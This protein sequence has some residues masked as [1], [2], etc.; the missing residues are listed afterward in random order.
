MWIELFRPHQF[1][2]RYREYGLIFPNFR[3]QSTVTEETVPHNICGVCFKPYNAPRILPCLH[4]LCQQFLH[5]E[6]EKS[7]SQQ[8]FKCPTCERS[9]GIPVGGASVLPHNLHLGFQVQ[10]A[11]YMSK[12]VSNSEVCC[13]ECIDGHN[14]PAVVFCCTCRQFLCKLCHD[15]HRSSRKLSKHDTVGLDHEGAKHVQTTMKPREY[16]CSQPKHEDN[17]LNFYCVSCNMLVCRDC[18]RVAHKD[19]GVSELSTVAEALQDD[20]RGTLQ[21]VQDTLAGAIDANEKTMKQVETSK[22]EAELAIKQAFEQLHAKLE[23]RKKSLLSELETIA[24]THT[25]S[26]IFQR[27][28]LEKIQHDISHYPEV[29]SHILQTHTDHEVV[30]MGELIVSELKATLRKVQNVSSS[31]SQYD[32]IYAHLQIDSLLQEVSRLGYVYDQ[33]P[34]P[35][36]SIITFPSVSRINTK[37][38]MKLDTRMLNGERCPHGG[39]QVEAEMRSNAQNGAVVYGEVEDHRDGTYTIALTPQ[40]AGP[41]QLVITMDG[42]HV[43]NSPHDLDVRPKYSNLTLCNVITHRKSFCISL[44]D[45][46]DIYVV[47]LRRH[48]I[49]VYDQTGQLKNTI[50]SYGSGDGQFRGPSGICIKGDVLYVADCK[51]HRVQKLTSG[52]EFLHHFGQKAGSGQG[53][54]K[55]P[56]AVIVDSNNRLIVAD[57]NNHRIQIFNEDGGWLLTIDGNSSGNPFLR[58]PRCFALDPQGNIHVGGHCSNGIEVFTK[59]G[60]Y[61]RMYGDPKGPKGIAIDDEGYSLVSDDDYHISVYDSQGRKIKTVENLLCGGGIALDPRDGRDGNVYVTAHLGVTVLK[62]RHDVL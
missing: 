60:V 21:C 13:D 15:H 23:E 34:A 36:K 57:T 51:N 54:F 9:T 42:Q 19:H 3:S 59:E 29:T 6:I 7:G 5:H 58:F 8:V 1:V 28:Q 2:I 10:V 37:C 12:I 50:G 52:G 22:Q 25:A 45:N 17:K 35:C 38:L 18:T 27:E 56:S 39:V 33:S 20:M 16:Y 30:A 55:S 48:C 24:L 4:S 11:E 62:C 43:Q 40:T 26:L 53:Q 61:V 32:L 41:H 46:G 47:E 14:G 44:H 31:T 49:H